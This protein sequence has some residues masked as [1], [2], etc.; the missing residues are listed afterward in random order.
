[1]PRNNNCLK[2]KV[3]FRYDTLGSTNAAAVA[4]LHGTAPP[5]HGD[6]F[7]SADQSAGRGQ[8]SNR[9]HS[10]PGANLTLSVVLRPDDLAVDDLFRLSQFAALAVAGA[11]EGC[12]GGEATGAVRVKWPNDVYVGD[13]KIAGILVQNGLRGSRVAW[14]VVGI[15]LNVG[16]TDFPAELKT[17]AT[18]LR[19]LTGRTITPEAVLPELFGQLAAG[20]PHCLPNPPAGVSLDEAYDGLLYRKD[21]ATD[22]ELTA[23]GQRFTGIIRGVDGRGRLRVEQSVGRQSRFVVGEVRLASSGRG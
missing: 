18:S 20:Y 11:V 10:S 13:R 12:L 23:T 4:A 3:S 9:W 6:V 1:M 8:G 16:E 7:L 17:K 21:V 14:S 15:G 19:L 22:F 2:A 5:A